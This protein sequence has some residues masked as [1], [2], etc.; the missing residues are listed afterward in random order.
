MTSSSPPIY[1]PHK[2]PNLI[3][4]FLVIT[5]SLTEFFLCWGIKDWSSSECPQNA[6]QRFHLQVLSKYLLRNAWVME[7]SGNFI[8]FCLVESGTFIP[9]VWC[10]FYHYFNFGKFPCNAYETFQNMCS[11][12]VFPPV[13]QSTACVLSCFS[14]TWL[15]ATPWTVAQSGLLCPWDF[16]GKNTGVGCHFLLQGIFPT[17]RSNPHLFCLLRW[18][19]NSLPL[20][21]PGKPYPK[22]C[23]KQKHASVLR[24]VILKKWV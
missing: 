3:N 11:I 10:W 22:H 19:E 1:K 13:T 14:P 6:T 16:P 9:D 24:A 7:A 15:F 21:P 12:W 17:Q 8:I 5:F 20:A 18:Q 4:N 23:H 2:C